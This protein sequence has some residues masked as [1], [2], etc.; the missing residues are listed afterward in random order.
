MV[1]HIKLTKNSLN[2]KKKNI[3]CNIHYD[4]FF[5]YFHL[6]GSKN[7]L[8][9]SCT[10][11][12]ECEGGDNSIMLFVGKNPVAYKYKFLSIEIFCDLIYNKAIQNIRV[13]I[14]KEQWEM[15]LSKISSPRFVLEGL[16]NLWKCF[17][18]LT[19]SSALTYFNFITIFFVFRF[20]GAPINNTRIH[21]YS[22][23]YLLSRIF[24]EILIYL[25]CK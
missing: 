1:N 7:I 6:R 20:G 22:W 2:S 11:W 25:F 5:V 19:K 15:W 14:C 18:H 12:L 9:K 16:A 8:S 13:F 4:I 21:S 23:K 3:E 10:L 17:N 24:K